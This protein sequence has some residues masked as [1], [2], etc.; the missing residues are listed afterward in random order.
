MLKIDLV[1][2]FKAMNP[3]IRR[4]EACIWIRLL[5]QLPSMS[6]EPVPLHLPTVL[7]ELLHTR[8]NLSSISGYMADL[9]RSLCLL[10]FSDWNFELLC[11]A[12]PTLLHLTRY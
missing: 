3:L 10:P 2:L 5:E 12:L 9:L 4:F 8:Y 11:V 7:E 6:L 1:T